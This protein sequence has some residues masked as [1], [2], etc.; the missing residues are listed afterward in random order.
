MLRVKGVWI[1]S[2]VGKGLLSVGEME[3]LETF[4]EAV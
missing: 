1:E 2:V 3:S 4:P